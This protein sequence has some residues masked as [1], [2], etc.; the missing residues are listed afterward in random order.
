M[1]SVDT[2]CHKVD[3]KVPSYNRFIEY[4][5]SEFNTS[6]N[7]FKKILKSPDG[8]LYIDTTIRLEGECTILN[9]HTS[10]SC[11]L[12]YSLKSIVVN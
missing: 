4:F 11:S 12:Q 10:I 6:S 2:I 1:V 3:I 9:A 5:D 8:D 7:F